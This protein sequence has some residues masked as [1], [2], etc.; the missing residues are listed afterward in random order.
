MLSHSQIRATKHIQAVFRRVKVS[1]SNRR[2]TD[3]SASA[4][5]HAAPTN[6]PHVNPPT[7]VAAHIER[8]VEVQF[9]TTRTTIPSI[10]D[11]SAH[12]HTAMQTDNNREAPSML[13]NA[14]SPVDHITNLSQLV[15]GVDELWLMQT[16]EMF[17]LYEHEQTAAFNRTGEVNPTLFACLAHY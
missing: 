14:S 4:S 9:A 3:A 1:Q 10:T 15:W 12:S 2:A 11:A 5:D 17:A 7:V 6:K 13:P 8:D 16:K